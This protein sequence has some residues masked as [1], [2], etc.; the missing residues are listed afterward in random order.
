MFKIWRLLIYDIFMKLQHMDRCNI[1]TLVTQQKLKLDNTEVQ[2]N[3]VI[4]LTS[5]DAWLRSYTFF[6]VI[7]R[8]F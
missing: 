4:W 7:V 1:T 8:L 3:S 5:Q 6:R 2:H